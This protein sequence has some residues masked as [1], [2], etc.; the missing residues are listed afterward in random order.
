MAADPYSVLG[1]PRS[2]SDDELKKAY[3]KLAKQLHPDRHKD[4]PAAAERFKT[5]SAAYAILGDPDKRAQYDRGQL[6]ADG[7]QRHFSSAGPGSGFRH[8]GGFQ[9]EADPFEAFSDLFARGGSPF[10]KRGSPKGRTVEYTL[11]VPFETAARAETQRLRLSS[12]KAIDMKIPPGFTDGQQVRL[13]GQGE[14]GPGGTGDALVTLKLAP[15]AWYE[16]DGDVIRLDVPIS[17]SEAVLGAS[18]RVPTVDGPVM[19]TVPP[20]STSGRVLRLRGRGFA[21]RDGGRGDQ[22][23]R[24]LVDLP[25]NDP[26]LRTFVE[27]WSGKGPAKRP[28]GADE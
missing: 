5:V 19:L 6:D 23:V 24:L 15:H 26:A 2:A 1:V 27:G 13:A 18:I 16:R 8:G 17:L 22:R 4:D 11:D 28:F 7:N 9:T 10:G 25:P 20:N 21:T 12:G 14:P 3:R